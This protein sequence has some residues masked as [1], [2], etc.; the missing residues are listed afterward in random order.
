MPATAPT[1]LPSTTRP[2]TRCRRAAATADPAA[3]AP[4]LRACE[5]GAFGHGAEL[6]PDHHRIDRGLADPGAVAAIGPGHHVLAADQVGIA[7]DALRHELG[8]LD[9]VRFRFEHAGNEQLA[10]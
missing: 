6:C 1:R 4:E 10:F 7:R 5:A 2:K 8:M 3:S 9:E